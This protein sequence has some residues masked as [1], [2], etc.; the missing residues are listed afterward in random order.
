[1]YTPIHVRLC[2]QKLADMAEVLDARE[3]RQVEMSEENVAL[4]EANNVLRKYCVY[5]FLTVFFRMSYVW[6]FSN[7]IIRLL[8]VPQL[9][10]KL[11]GRRLADAGNAL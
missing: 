1:M 7:E 10:Q 8:T 11:R 6:N 4:V 5:T 9:T 2:V 3:R